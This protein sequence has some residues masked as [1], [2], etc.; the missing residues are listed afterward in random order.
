M[1]GWNSARDRLIFH[2]VSRLDQGETHFTLYL[3]KNDGSKPH[4]LLPQAM[5]AVFLE[6]A[7]DISS[8]SPFFHYNGTDLSDLCEEVRDRLGIP[9]G[10]RIRVDIYDKRLG[11]FHRKLLKSFPQ[12][13]ENVYV[14][15]KVEN[16][17]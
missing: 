10:A 15:L 16:D 1:G 5:V 13:A 14:V 2:T 8:Y 17:Q 11:I 12:D 7:H 9:K 3:F 6:N 4:E